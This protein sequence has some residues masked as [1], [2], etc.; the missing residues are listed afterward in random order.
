MTNCSPINNNT[1]SKITVAIPAYNAMEYLPQ[2][3]ASVL[4][5]TYQNFEV[6]I[7]NDGS[8]DGIEDWFATIEDTR[9]KLI[10]QS[11]QGLAGARNT[12][13][14][15]ATGEYI[16]LLDADDLWGTTKLAKQIKILDD[17]PEVGLVYTWASL[18]DERSKPIGKLHKWEQQGQV[19]EKLLPCNP[20]IPSSVI[21][22]RTCFDRVG[23]FDTNLLSYI[24]DWD[25][26]L[27]LA[28]HYQFAVIK[29]P[30]LYYRER[31]SSVS[32]NWEGMKQSFEI[33]IEK[34]FTDAPAN[35]M[36]IKKISYSLA[37]QHLAAQALNSQNPD[38]QVVIA[39]RNL[40]VS[41]NP[42]LRFSWRY[43]RGAI[44]IASSKLFGFQTY[45]KVLG[46]F[47]NLR[48]YLTPMQNS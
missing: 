5:Q 6:I 3:L 13:V 8:T 31:S 39:L 41:Y 11:N 43:W 12:G 15:Q 45:K 2:T 9:V 27:R 24:E 28:K 4:K 23:S 30:L 29:E 35:L 47:Q 40:A 18:I 7:V 25:M 26:W 16:A 19:W 42:R 21:I 20:I 33:V 14:Q 22:R 46:F 10:S 48:G 32:K 38:L 37:Y 36:S 17:N 34:A 1:K 44:A